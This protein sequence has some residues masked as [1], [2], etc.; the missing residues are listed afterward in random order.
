VPAPAATAL[1][2]AL[3]LR[4]MTTFAL[5]PIL[6]NVATNLIN[7]VVVESAPPL[8]IQL[9]FLAFVLLTRLAIIAL[10]VLAV[11]YAL[12]V[13]RE[14]KTGQYRGRGSA[15]VALVW[16]GIL[17]AGVLFFFISEVIGLIQLV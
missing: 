15:I 11:I 13:L 14:T 10:I 6:V 7:R 8:E 2:P 1:P 9:V 3:S 12:R 5:L 17:T 4:R 16:C